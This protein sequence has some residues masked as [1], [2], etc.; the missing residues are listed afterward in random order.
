MIVKIL[1]FVIHSYAF[2]KWQVLPYDDCMN[3]TLPAAIVEQLPYLT[4]GALKTYVALSSIK[5]THNQYPTQDD[6][7]THMNVSSRSVLTYLKELERAG[8]IEKRRFGSGR[9]TDYVLISE[10]AYGA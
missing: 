2:G 6:L 9:R 5:A 3:L 7:A 10:H 1:Q 4:S 8:Y